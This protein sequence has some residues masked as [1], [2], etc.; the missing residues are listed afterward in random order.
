[1]PL[2]SARGSGLQ[3]PQGSWFPRPSERTLARTSPPARARP[4]VGSFP[5]GLGSSL[6]CSWPCAR[7]ERAV[8]A[9]HGAPGGALSACTRTCRLHPWLAR[10]CRC[11]GARR[12]CCS[13][14]PSRSSQQAG[15]AVGWGGG[16]QGGEQ[17]WA[18]TQM[19]VQGQSH[20]TG[21]RRQVTG[22]GDE[23][24]SV[25]SR[26]WGDCTVGRACAKAPCEKEPG[27][28]GSG[29]AGCSRAG[30]STPALPSAEGA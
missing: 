9:G 16:G 18:L 6:G 20:H 5:S 25:L 29:W 14:L 22:L 23:C 1:M 19:L 21:L 15:A 3:P 17:Q 7:R 12:C 28:G 8:R 13:V 30:C 2:R 24:E 27:V 4:L 10:A 11:L 26:Q